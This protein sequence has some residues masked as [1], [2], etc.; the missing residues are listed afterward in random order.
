MNTLQ[1]YHYSFRLVN[2]SKNLNLFFQILT[3]YF[4]HKLT[5][6]Y[7]CPRW[8]FSLGRVSISNVSHI[9]PP[10]AEIVLVHRNNGLTERI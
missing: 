2:T 3:R 10:P 4:L 5:F 6:L 1:Q 8:R 7:V 9:T